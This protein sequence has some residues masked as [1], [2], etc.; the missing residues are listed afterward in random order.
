[1]INAAIAK[2]AQKSSLKAKF[3]AFPV[4]ND[5]QLFSHARSGVSSLVFYQFAAAINMPDKSLAGLLN[6]SPRTISN[7]QEKQKPLAP[8]Q[9]EHLLKLIALYNKGEELFGNI[10]EFSYWLNKPFWNSAE[11][12]VD[13][14]I[15]PG[16]IDLVMLEMDRLAYGYPA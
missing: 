9:G 6:L 4:E 3:K 15:T 14:L 2:P 12:P 1:M 5:V 11:K 7:Y 10:D 8:A 13:W 16:G